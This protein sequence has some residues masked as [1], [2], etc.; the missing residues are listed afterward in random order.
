MC[1][2]FEA[3]LSEVEKLRSDNGELTR[4]LEIVLASNESLRSNSL[5]LQSR[6]AEL[7][8]ELS[9]KEAEWSQKE[10]RFKAEVYARYSCSCCYCLNI[11]M[12][13]STGSQ[14]HLRPSQC[15]DY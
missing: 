4:H 5:L 3:L 2:D 11:I 7:L 9:V 12:R 14:M 13:N 8:E 10:D 1:T 15:P 6:S